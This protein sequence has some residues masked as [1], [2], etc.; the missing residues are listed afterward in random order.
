MFLR[1]IYYREMF[2]R[3]IYYREMFLRRIYY[4][5]MFLRRIYYRVNLVNVQLKTFTFKYVVRNIR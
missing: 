3:R 2:L 4:R 5:E 1:R